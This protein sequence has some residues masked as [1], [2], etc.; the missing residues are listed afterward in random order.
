MS[1]VDQF[2]SRFGGLTEQYEFYNGKVILHYDPK[3]HVY[4]LVKDGDLI[5]QEGVTNVCHIIDKSEALIP[6]AVKQMA[7][8]LL[9]EAVITLPDGSKQMR[10]MQYQEFENLVL[11]S[12]TAHRDKLEEAGDVGHIAHAWIERYIKAILAHGAASVQV[13]EVL[14]KFPVDERAMNCCLAALDWMRDH[15]VRWLG[16]ERKIYSRK[17]GYAGTMDG[18]CLVDSCSDPHCCKKSFKDR[19]TISDWKTSNYLYVEYLLQTAAYMQAYNEETE[20][21]EIQKKTPLMER[22]DELVTDRWII[23][24]GKEDAD[25]DPWHA[26]A[27]DFQADWDGFNLALDLKQTVEGIRKRT[28][29][30]EA[31]VRENI[32]AERKALREAAE[33]A[34]KERKAAERAK[35]KEERLEALKLKCKGADKYQGKRR[36]TCGCVSCAVRYQQA[37]DR[38]HGIIIDPSRLLGSGFEH[39]RSCDGEHSMPRC[40]SLHCWQTEYETRPDRLLEAPKPTLYTIGRYCSWMLSSDENG[41]AIMVPADNIID[42]MLASNNP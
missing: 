18:L 26:P 39:S 10:A 17:H 12:K 40:G 11:A 2:I 20:Y 35:A 16:T 33:A 36:P 32:K 9:T 27:E 19:L 31:E 8:M 24:L 15:N 22:L 28:K 30:R 29:D 21:V 13:Q 25:F 34:E 37:Q 7:A 6:W 38:K 42:A 1:N 3:A 41:N 5:P 14:A 4:L 23:R